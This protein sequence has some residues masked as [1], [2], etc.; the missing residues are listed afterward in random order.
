MA[1]ALG[2]LIQVLQVATLPYI[3]N[4]ITSLNGSLKSLANAVSSI[5][6]TLNRVNNT[7]TTEIDIAEAL[8]GAEI[9]SDALRDDFGLARPGGRDDL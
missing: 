8:F 6:S 3:G 4:Q 5:N 7:L 2:T 1:K 9:V